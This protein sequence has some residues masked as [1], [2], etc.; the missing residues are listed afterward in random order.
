[1]TTETTTLADALRVIEEQRREIER[2]RASEKEWRSIV[3]IAKRDTGCPDWLT[4]CAHLDHLRDDL[5]RVAYDRDVLRDAIDNLAAR[6]ANHSW[7]EDG[8]DISDLINT[9]ERLRALA[10]KD[11]P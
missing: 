9:V 3:L 6:Y 8:A 1:V 11:Q 10:R 5:E 4:L 7:A 2:L